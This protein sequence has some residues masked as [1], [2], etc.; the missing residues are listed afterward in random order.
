MP[1]NVNELKSNKRTVVVPY[2]DSDTVKV[3]YQPSVLTPVAEA[4]YVAAAREGDNGPMLKMLS[5]LILEWDVM[6]SKEKPL[7]HTPDVL[8][9][10]PSALMTAIM[11]A[12]QEDMAP[13]R[14]RGRSSFGR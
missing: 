6:E 10:L 13:N 8:A 3:T 4:E 9:Q 7:P 12:I 11:T 14:Q 1:I 5:E 2:L